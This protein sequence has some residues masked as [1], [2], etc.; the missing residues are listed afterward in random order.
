MSKNEVSKRLR[1]IRVCLD[2]ILDKSRGD[3]RGELVSLAHQAHAMSESL[4]TSARKNL[5]T[6][7]IYAR[8]I[9]SNHRI[10]HSSIKKMNYCWELFLKNK[11]ANLTDA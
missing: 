8:K 11:E 9:S 5:R 1:T 4:P 6:I 7:L 3:S 2:G 10:H